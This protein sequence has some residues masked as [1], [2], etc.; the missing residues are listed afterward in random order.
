MFDPSSIQGSLREFGFDGWLLYDFRGSNV[1]ARR[2]L[3][4]GEKP[5][6][7]RFF[8]MI[9]ASGEPSKLVHAIEPNALEHLPGPRTIYRS[10]QGL[11]EGVAALV[12]DAKRVAMEYAPGL[13]NP[14]ISRV[15]A[16]TIEFVR[17][18]GID[19]VSSGDLIQLYESA[20]DDEQW[21]MHRAAD[22]VTTTAFD[23]AWRFIADR[24]RDGGSVRETEVQATILHHFEENDLTTYSPPNVSAGPHS[25]DP[26]YEPVAGGDAEIRAGDFVLIDLWGKLKRPRSVYS[27]LTRV[28]FV[29]DAVP[30]KYESIF[31]VVADA[32]DAAIDLVRERFRA[33]R[34]L[35]GYEVDDAAR[36]VIRRAGH[37]SR[38]THRTGHNIGQEV[39]GN[40]ANMD[41]LETHDERLVL[42]RTCF[43]IEPG[44][45]FEEFGVRSEVDVFVDAAGTVHVT[46]GLQE[47]VVPILA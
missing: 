38:F 47:S 40:G 41:N 3:G 39:H 9:P 19:V 23:V 18:L 1:P 6:S 36:D 42:P 15:D 27:D 44:I 10:W 46:G 24:T 7:R 12:G 4:L 35:R 33:G 13:S 32:R 37:E 17:K 31:R 34:P 25:G 16:G 21:A 5:G 11:Q 20:W 29:G 8:Y 14:Y 43:S 30:E 45:Y 28:G 26:H 22:R 2:L